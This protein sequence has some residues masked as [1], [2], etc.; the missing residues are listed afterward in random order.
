MVI[1]C[2]INIWEH[3]NSYDEVVED[4]FALF[5]D[6]VALLS[7][8]QAQIITLELLWYTR[9]HHCKDNG[10]NSNGLS[11]DAQVTPAICCAKVIEQLLDVDRLKTQI[12]PGDCTCAWTRSSATAYLKRFQ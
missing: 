4:I 12:K 3:F 9:R 10:P 8:P 6:L 7:S 11:S 1:R 5:M 2:R